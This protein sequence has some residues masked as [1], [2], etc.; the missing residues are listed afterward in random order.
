M[1]SEAGERVAEA[2]GIAD[3]D[4]V[5]AALDEFRKNQTHRVLGDSD[6]RQ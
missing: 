2:L 6:P 5:A 3:G 1:L 4:D